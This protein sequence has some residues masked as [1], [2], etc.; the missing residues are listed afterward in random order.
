VDAY[1]GGIE[2]AI[3]HLLYSRFIA[4]FLHSCGKWPSGGGPEN[5]GEPFK[6]LI[7]QGMVLG[8]TYTHPRTKQ[9]L[10]PEELKVDPKTNTVSVIGDGLTPQIS[11]EK[12]SKSKFNGTDP[13]ECIERWGADA[14][15]AHLLFQGRVEDQLEWDEDRIIGIHRWFSKLWKH[16]NSLA[17]R[18]VNPEF[19]IKPNSDLH[20]IP[21]DK[22]PPSDREL[23]GAVQLSIRN[24]TFYL[25]K[26]LALNTVISALIKLTNSIIST[27]KAQTGPNELTGNQSCSLAMSY[28]ATD[29]LLR[30]LAPV[31]PAF[32]EEC[33]EVLHAQVPQMAGTRALESTW[34]W[35]VAHQGEEFGGNAVCAIQI[36]GKV[37]AKIEV[38]RKKLLSEVGGVRY[39]KRRVKREELVQK[40]LDG[41]KRE[42]KK[43]FISPNGKV[44]NLYI[45]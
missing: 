36:N 12:M 37:R 3:L 30:M 45:D 23:W 1:V 14:T 15:R 28:R 17:P 22:L 11:W 43:V 6:R 35:F 32:S 31:A 20:N 44:V 27:T 33:W 38:D 7:T 19:K 5:E 41:G 34:P 26:S 4:K 13:Q 42:I 16:V 18:L 10:A 24:I 9:V 2:H 21:I 25:S 29:V 39:I 40:W 8:K